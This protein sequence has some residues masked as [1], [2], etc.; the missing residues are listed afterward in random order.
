MLSS[1]QQKTQISLY[2]ACKNNSVLRAKSALDQGAS[3]DLPDGTA[4]QNM[5]IH[6]AAMFGAS[7]TIQLLFERGADLHAKNQRGRTALD[8]ARR[9]GEKEAAALLETLAE[10]GRVHLEGS[11]DDDDDDNEQAQLSLFDACRSNEPLLATDA[12]LGGAD[13]DAA[14]G[15]TASNRPLHVAAVY[16]ACEVIELL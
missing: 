14:D 10:G 6:I 7:H 8:V 15:S 12:I 16:G 13:V 2:R 4:G 3:I 9:I 1:R 5:P 11:G